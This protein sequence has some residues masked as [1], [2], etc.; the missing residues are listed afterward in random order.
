[1]AL[2]KNV[3]IYNAFF[4]KKT[5]CFICRHSSQPAMISLIRYYTA[6]GWTTMN[7]AKKVITFITMPFIYFLS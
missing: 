3:K 7:Y 4:R 6:R 2:H 5:V 1:M